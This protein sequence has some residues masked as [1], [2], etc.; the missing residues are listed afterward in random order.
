MCIN[1]ET[2]LLNASKPNNTTSLLLLLFVFY[3]KPLNM[4]FVT[5]HRKSN[6]V[7]PHR[8][9]DGGKITAGGQRSKTRGVNYHLAAEKKH[10]CKI[11]SFVK[12]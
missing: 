5:S 8:R 11:I 12:K 1:A 9:D 3:S 4:F 6:T 10:I 7:F 2:N